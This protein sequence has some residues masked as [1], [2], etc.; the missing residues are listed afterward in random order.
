MGGY[1]DAFDNHVRTKLEA[2]FGKAVGM[3]I[4]A[5]ASN[6]SGAATM[7]IGAEEYTRLC[8]AIAGDE[9]VVGMWGV[10]GAQ[11]AL[12]QWKNAAEIS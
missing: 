4:L 3:L 8:D 10:S 2:S 11:D 7:G 6:K 5:S 12:E 9:R 1:Q